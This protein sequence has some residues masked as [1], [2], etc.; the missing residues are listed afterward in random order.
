MKKVKQFINKLKTVMN[1]IMK[2]KLFLMIAGAVAL[3]VVLVVALVLIFSNNK[4][5]SLKLSESLKELGVD[6]Y[7]NFY[8]NQISKNDKERKEFLEK[9]KD[10]GI[11]VSLD[12]IA[13]HK[14][15]AKEE[16]LAE[17][18]NSKTKEECDRT[19]TMVVIY[20]KEPYGKSDHVVDAILV[21]G[22]EE[23]ET[24]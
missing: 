5:E 6:F 8:Y 17:F 14:I 4:N 2:N 3:I 16:I 21:C 11:K 15:D 24:K 9:Y 7:E 10:L 18:V 19:N 22:F 20:P 1:K 13:R 23:T 12:S